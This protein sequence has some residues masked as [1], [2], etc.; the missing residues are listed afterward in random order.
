MT[1][2]APC[3][4]CALLATS[5]RQRA[6]AVALTAIHDRRIDMA[7]AG[8]RCTELETIAGEWDALSTTHPTETHRRYLR[9]R[10]PNP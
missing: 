2:G 10:L 7:D 6:D 4:L 5:A 8:D 1:P 9:E 3:E